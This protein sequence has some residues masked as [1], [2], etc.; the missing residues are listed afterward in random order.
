MARFSHWQ[1]FGSGLALGFCLVPLAGSLTLAAGDPT[2]PATYAPGD[3]L[4]ARLDARAAAFKREIAAGDVESVVEGVTRLD[5]AVK[6]GDLEGARAAWIAARVGW[7]RSEIF[8]ADLFPDLDKAIDTWPDATS[9]FHAVEVKLFGANPQLPVAETHQLLDRV[10]RYQRVFNQL[11]FK[12]QY[13][14]AGM[15]TLAYEMGENK[16]KGGESL[17]SGTSLNDLQ[18]NIEGLDRGWHYLFADEVAAK[19]PTMA[20]RVDDEM[21][22]LKAMLAVSSLDDLQPGA[23]EREA[24]LL[25]GSLADSAVVL[26]WKAPDFTEEGE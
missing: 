26:G 16:S 19:N 21:A 8:T 4:L 20:K 1:R 2:K 25:A 9:G 15:A 12:G 14:I 3:V 11:E 13:L 17:A 5:A 6:A 10:Q 7:E 23:M 22:G 24:E 18:H